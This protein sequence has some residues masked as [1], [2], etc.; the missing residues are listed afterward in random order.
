MPGENTELE[1]CP[2]FDPLRPISHTML[3]RGEPKFM[4]ELS[5]LWPITT[6]L[7]HN[8]DRVVNPQVHELSTF[9]LITAHLPHNTDRGRCQVCEPPS[10]WIVH[11]LTHHDP[12][13]TQHWQGENPSSCINC[14]LFDPSQPTQPTHHHLSLTWHWAMSTFSPVSWRS[15]NGMRMCVHVCVCVCAR[16]YACMRVCVRVCVCGCVCVRACMEWSW[17]M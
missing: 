4:H 3:T 10:S 7:P 8:T 17:S 13:P 16:V 12:S 15:S 1:N 9:W 6:Y 11:I 14:P 2:H 5:A